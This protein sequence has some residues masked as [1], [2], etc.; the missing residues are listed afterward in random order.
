M[1]YAKYRPFALWAQFQVTY[2]IIV[3]GLVLDSLWARFEP[4]FQ[5]WPRMAS[6][7][8]AIWGSSRM[9]K[10]FHVPQS[11]WAN[12]VTPTWD[13]SSFEMEKIERWKEST[14]HQLARTATPRASESWQRVVSCYGA[15]SFYTVYWVGPSLTVR[16]EILIHG[17][18]VR[19]NTGWPPPH[20]C[21]TIDYILQQKV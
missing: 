11:V 13:M 16:P 17:R 9:G 1:G 2:G 8:N 5:A 4:V 3:T 6:V 14:W 7:S 10:W 19:V 20:I 12:S 15:I 21:S 18:E